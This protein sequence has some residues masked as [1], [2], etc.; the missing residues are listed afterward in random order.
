MPLQADRLPT[1]RRMKSRLLDNKR[2]SKQPNS[3]LQ[4]ESERDRENMIKAIGISAILGLL[5]AG[6]AFAQPSEQ[7]CNKQLKECALRCGRNDDCNRRCSEQIAQCMNEARAY[8]NAH[9]G[10]QMS[11]AEMKAN[12]FTDGS[13]YRK[14]CR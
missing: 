3:R 2:S 1:L 8:L 11:C 6:G 9:P 4:K 12:N 10:R 13:Y 14:H 7:A 5:A